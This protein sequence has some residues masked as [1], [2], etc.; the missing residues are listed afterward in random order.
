M[1]HD[2][3]GILS[4]DGSEGRI[5]SHSK[6]MYAFNRFYSGREEFGPTSGWEL[7]WL[8]SLERYFGENLSTFN[9]DAYG[10]HES[11]ASD[12]A[13]SEAMRTTGARLL[14]MI[15]HKGWAWTRDFISNE[16]LRTLR[17]EGVRIIAIWGDPQVPAQRRQLRSLR[18]TVDLNLCTGTQS[19]SARL[20]HRDP[21]MYAWVPV[22]DQRVRSHCDCGALV[23]FAGSL[24]GERAQVIHHLRE[25]GIQVHSGGGEGVTALSRDEYLQIMAHPIS[26][27]FSQTDLETL[28]NMRT[29]EVINQGVVLMEQ[30]GRETAKLLTPYQEYVPWYDSADLIRQVR[31]LSDDPARRRAIARAGLEASARFDNALLWDTAL[32]RIQQRDASSLEPAYAIDWTRYRGPHPRI[33]RLEDRLTRQRWANAVVFTRLHSRG[34]RQRLKGGPNTI[35][36]SLSKLAQRVHPETDD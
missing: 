28:A 14:V 30:W 24:K 29:F 33:A 27:S 18:G 31:E 11:Q 23:G 12:Q 25:Q 36:R 17:R 8:K 3:V 2:K 7:N 21:V 22:H 1:S 4:E 20:A 15:N 9:P 32:E 16:T 6:V 34:V 35:A 19:V 13:L 26:L 10:P 5:T